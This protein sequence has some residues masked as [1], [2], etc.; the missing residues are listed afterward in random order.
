VREQSSHTITR[1][2][3]RPHMIEFTKSVAN[4]PCPQEGSR[5]TSLAAC[6]PSTSHDASLLPAPQAISRRNCWPCCRRRH[7]TTHRTRRKSR[8]VQRRRVRTGPVSPTSSRRISTAP[9]ASAAPWTS[10]SVGRGCWTMIRSTAAAALWRGSGSVRSTPV[11]LVTLTYPL[12]ST[13]VIGM[14]YAHS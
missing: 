1:P 10:R 9:T 8:W 11:M 7:S 4:K 13:V 3:A 5:A 6:K 12:L 14:F 2:T